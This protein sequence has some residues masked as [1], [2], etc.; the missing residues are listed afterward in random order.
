LA[1][2]FPCRFR[3]SDLQ[4]SALGRK[5]GRYVVDNVFQPVG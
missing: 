1:F 4:G 3:N 2:R 5:V